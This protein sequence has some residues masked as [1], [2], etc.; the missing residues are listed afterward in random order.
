MKVTKQHSKL[1]QQ[2]QMNIHKFARVFINVAIT[3]IGYGKLPKLD[4]CFITTIS[5]VPVAV[6]TWISIAWLRNETEAA[7]Q[8]HSLNF[9][10]TRPHS[11][12]T[13]LNCTS[14]HVQKLKWVWVSVFD[15]L[16]WRTIGP[17]SF[18]FGTAQLSLWASGTVNYDYIVT[19]RI[20][21]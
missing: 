14:R 12:I 4:C 6:S 17:K 21:S 15:K 11:L 19:N 16:I 18:L 1:W 8:Q 9:S 10:G 20:N 7:M 5:P 2:K 13:R 3:L